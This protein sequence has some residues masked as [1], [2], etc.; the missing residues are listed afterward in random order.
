MAT[1]TTLPTLADAVPGNLLPDMFGTGVSHSEGINE[2]I[3]DIY[4]AWAKLGIGAS[5]A[6]ANTVLRGTG[7]GTTAFGQV[8]DGDITNA[9][10]TAAKIAATAWTAFTPTLTQSGSVTLTVNYARYR[11]VGKVANL[12]VMVTATGAGT[13][14]NAVILGG[15]P[16]AVEPL[17]TGASRSV[18][19]ALVVDASTSVH[20]QANIITFSSTTM[21]FIASGYTNYW[22]VD[23]AIA[24]ANGDSI[25]FSVTYEIA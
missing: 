8:V 15:I 5:T 14:S 18:G 1:P 17:Q 10:I 6:T 25:S 22:G 19:S 3:D 23:P 4:N 9:T 13:V 7:A 2:M 16:S 21:R 11:A 24:L 20:Y 12:Q